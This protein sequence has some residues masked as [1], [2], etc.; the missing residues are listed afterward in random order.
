ML[1]KSPYIVVVIK[2]VYML[3]ELLVAN[4]LAWVLYFWVL[5]AVWSWATT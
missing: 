1:A 4:P 3:F 2:G 5:V